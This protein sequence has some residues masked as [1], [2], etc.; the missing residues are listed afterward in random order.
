MYY[1]H[2]VHVNSQLASGS[3]RHSP[4]DAQRGGPGDICGR[5]IIAVVGYAQMFSLAV[6][7]LAGP[8]KPLAVEPTVG[9]SCSKDPRANHI[10]WTI[11]SHHTGITYPFFLYSELRFHQRMRQDNLWHRWVCA[12]TDAL[13]LDTRILCQ[14]PRIVT[15][16]KH[17]WELGGRKFNQPALTPSVGIHPTNRVSSVQHR[18]L[19]CRYFPILSSNCGCRSCI[20]LGH[21]WYHF[22][23][24]QWGRRTEG[25]HNHHQ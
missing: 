21:R 16:R 9:T 24:H 23:R 22:E 10:R 15:Q 19:G 1:R 11:V 13:A 14:T 25:Q 6:R 2:P 17:Q 8:P 4:Q 20:T 3:E 7:S 18:P 12:N 5:S